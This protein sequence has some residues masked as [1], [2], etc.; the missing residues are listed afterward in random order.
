MKI[1]LCFL[2]ISIVGFSQNNISILDSETHEPVSYANIWKED[3]SIYK[4][5]D[6]LGIFSFVKNQSKEFKITAIGYKNKTLN[7][8]EKVIY[9]EPERTDLEE[10]KILSPKNKVHQKLGKAKRQ[11]GSMACQY[12]TKVAYIV[13]YFS[14]SNDV[15]F[16]KS[17]NFYTLSTSKTRKIG[18]L[19]YSVGENGEPDELLNSKNIICN[20]K[21]GSSLNKVN[22]SD[23]KIV[24]TEKGIYIGIKYLLIEDNKNYSE[25]A[26]FNP[27]SFFYEPGI[28]FSRNTTFKDSW[29]FDG[30]I[31]KNYPNWSLNFEIETTD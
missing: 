17:F 22:L 14:G 21:K 7:T 8:F 12:D 20:P 26:K 31:W 1:T 28:Y 2:F 16:L 27:L 5:A 30:I 3:S 13:K 15:Q 10:V 11:G 19:V 4:T 29:H 18:I 9:L 23:E 24:I 25:Y 6:S